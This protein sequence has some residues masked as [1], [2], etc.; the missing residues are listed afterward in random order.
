M[1]TAM[2]SS[3]PPIAVIDEL[4]RL[5]GSLNE[6]VVSKCLAAPR[7]I[8]ELNRLAGSLN[9]MLNA[10][11]ESEAKFRGLVKDAPDA[12]L[13]VDK[14]GRIVL[15]NDEAERLFGYT[16]QELLGAPLEMLEIGR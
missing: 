3:S 13:M 14:A 16:Q 8:D 4:N 11:A 12:M 7:V 10:L 15:A 6:C 1:R 5:A 2:Q 9:E